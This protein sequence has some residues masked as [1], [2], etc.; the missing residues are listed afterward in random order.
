MTGST[1]GPWKHHVRGQFIEVVSTVE[2]DMGTPA[3]VATMHELSIQGRRP[4]VIANARLIA[5]AP[6]LLAALERIV[7]WYHTD[8]P[9]DLLDDVILPAELAI[10]RARGEAVQS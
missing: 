10:A 6:E 2:Q 4:A 1:P 7:G 3:V 8:L 9:I 5:A